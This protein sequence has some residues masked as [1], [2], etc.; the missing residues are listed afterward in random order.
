MRILSPRFK[1]AG[2]AMRLGCL[3][4]AGGVA[5]GCTPKPFLSSGDANSATV[6]Y[7][8]DNLAA[9]TAVANR[10]C[11]RYERVARLL[12]AQEDMAYF[13]CHHP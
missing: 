6:G 5:A 4:L 8:G 10:H 9:A 13:E 11:A 12:E 1:H 3:I 2:S 7:G